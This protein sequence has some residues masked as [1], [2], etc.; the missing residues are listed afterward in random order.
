[1]EFELGGLVG[2]EFPAKVALVQEGGSTSASGM[3]AGLQNVLAQ[4]VHG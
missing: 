3:S 1:M 2:A 4:I